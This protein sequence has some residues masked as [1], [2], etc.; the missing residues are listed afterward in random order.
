MIV[1]VLF[2]DGQETGRWRFNGNECSP[3]V[4]A[5]RMMD[6]DPLVPSH[7]LAPLFAPSRPFVLQCTSSMRITE[8][9]TH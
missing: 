5:W 2:T 7:L 3:A 1:L 4:T 6:S 9:R 8:N